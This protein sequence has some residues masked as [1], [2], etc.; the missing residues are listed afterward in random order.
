MKKNLILIIIS[1]F[2]TIM[3]YA[4]GISLVTPLPHTYFCTDAEVTLLSDE[5]TGISSVIDIFDNDGQ[6]WLSLPVEIKEGVNTFKWDVSAFGSGSYIGIIRS[7]NSC[8]ILTSFSFDV[9][10]P[11][12]HEFKSKTRLSGG[13]TYTLRGKYLGMEARIGFYGADGEIAIQGI[14]KIKPGN[15]Y[16]KILFS[17]GFIIPDNTTIRIINESGCVGDFLVP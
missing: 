7:S 1:A 9:S 14:K 4:G 2:T 5:K 10:K 3:N 13:I 17:Y 15:N 12:I 6:Y 16:I 8:S 11:E